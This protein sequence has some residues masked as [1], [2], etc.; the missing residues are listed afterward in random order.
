[1]QH[2]LAPKK[3]AARTL[4]DPLPRTDVGLLL[5]RLQ[6][7]KSALSANDQAKAAALADTR[8]VPAAQGCVDYT[9]F[10]QDT[11]T[12]LASAHFCL[13]YRL[14]STGNAGSAT[15]AWAQKTLE[16]LEHVY[17]TEVTHLHYRKPLD[18]GDHLDDVFLDQIGDQGYYGFCTTDDASATST[19]WCE[20]DND[21]ATSEFGAAPINSLSVTAAH[22]FFHAIQF[23]YD[24]NDS[25]WFLEGTA[26]WMEDQV[27]PAINDY[28]QYLKYSQITQ[29]QVPIDTT[30]TFERYGAVIFW[31]YLS[32]GYHSVDIIRRIWDAASVS[33]STRN[34][35]QATIAV[36]RYDHIGWADA[37]ARFSLWN[38]LPAG[39]YAD[40]KL[41]PHPVTWGTARL[42]NSARDSGTQ[43]ISL[44]HLSSANVALIPSPALPSKARLTI[45]VDAPSSAVARVRLQVRKKNGTT[46]YETF[47][48]NSS[49]NGSRTLYFS[50][51]T[52]SSVRVTLANVTVTSN[53]RTFKFRARV[54]LP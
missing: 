16:V 53:N 43:T 41:F 40:R 26:V 34:A 17:T 2:A 25:T 32:E 1:V 4:G 22:E 18:D 7:S 11:W 42:G 39:S 37:F 54:R 24:A 3:A 28:L 9:P 5:H 12:A 44:D 38:T 35:I 23:A 36:L 8:P 19:A 47:T 27:Y 30:G 46:V 45:S 50:G 52:I 21:F 20:L 48:L 14:A 49:G 31:K 33:R 15:D 13:H 6:V 51:R 10:L 29:S